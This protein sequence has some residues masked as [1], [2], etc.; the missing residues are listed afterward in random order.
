MSDGV[1]DHPRFTS[2]S[3]TSFPWGAGDASTV[4][5]GGN[6][7][8]GVVTGLQEFLAAGRWRMF[9]RTPAVLGCSP[10]L[11]DPAGVDELVRFTDCCVVIAKPDQAHS[12]ARRLHDEGPDSSWTPSAPLISWPRGR[13]AAA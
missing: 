13:T 12:Q 10:W 11:S 7:L 1:G 9:C 2:W 6:V 4:R 3:G 8:D 5:F